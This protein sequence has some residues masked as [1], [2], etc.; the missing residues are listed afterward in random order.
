MT[1]HYCTYSECYEKKKPSEMYTLRYY[2]DD[3]TMVLKDF[4][5][6]EHLHEWLHER[7]TKT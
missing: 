2:L 1:K 3:G 4:C 5:T 6:L 7:Q